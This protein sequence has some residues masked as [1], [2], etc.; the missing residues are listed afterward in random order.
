MLSIVHP[1]DRKTVAEAFLR[2]RS[3]P[4]V[5]PASVY[6]VRTASGEWR[7]IEVVATNCLDDPAVAG[8]VI[9]ARDVTE[10]TN[11][12][13]VL[14]TLSEANRVLVSVPDEAS[15]L[16][17]VCRT[18]VDVGNYRLAWVGYSVHD[19]ERTVRPVGC[20]GQSGY[21]D[22]IA[23]SWR[24]DERG[25]GPVGAA[26]RT[27]SVQVVEDTC[28]A[29]EFAPWRAAAAEYGFRSCCA[30]PLKVNDEVIGALVIYAAEPAA[31]GPPEVALLKE[32]ADDLSYGVGRHR[33]AAS[34]QVSEERFRTLAAAA[35]IGIL[36]VSPMAGVNY[37]NPRVAEIITGREIG[38]LTGRGWLDALHPDD[39]PGLLAL[40]DGAGP[41]RAQVATKFRVKR[42]S[43]EVRHV[44]LLAAPRGRDVN[45]GYV[46]TVEDI[47]EE[48]QAQEALAHQA[49][50]DTLTGLPNRALFLDRLGQELARR[51]RDG[52]K[53]AVLFFDLDRFKVV[54]DSLGHQT[55][56]AVLKE[57]GDRFMR[58]VRAG[59]TAARFSGD[60]FVFIIREVHGVQDAF[61]AARRL[62]AV[63]EPPV[64]CGDHEITVT[65]SVGIAIPSAGADALTVLRDADAA[66]HQAKEEG[67]NRCALFD[68]ALHS[69]SVTRLAI[70]GELRQ[71]LARHELE[72]HY[73]PV[74]EPASGRPVGAEALVRWRHPA[75]GLVAPLDF[76]PVAEDSGLIKP[77]GRWVFEQAMGQLARWDAEDNG[78]RLEVLAVN[79][80]ARQ[81]DDP[82]T[83]DMVSH[84]LKLYGISPG[85]ACVEVTESAVMVDSVPTRHSL[86]A[87]KDLGLR[88]AID[89]FGT[90]YSSLAYLHTLPVT[91][92]KVDRSFVERLGGADDSTPVV[93]AVVEMGHAMGLGVVAEGVSSAH[94][95]ELVAHLGCDAAQGF[96]WA[97]AMPAEEFAAW[98]RKSQVLSSAAR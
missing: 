80:S 58:N 33:D 71:A 15:L 73:Q 10:R 60:M 2:D 1:D 81:L 54:N 74:V 3:M 34:L 14:R 62:Q 39:A 24:D 16:A 51:R 83:P 66:V 26:I 50:Y 64:R 97:R 65:G 57:L 63:L 84:A 72:L 6:R 40:F 69:R 5:H 29:E 20:A 78:P 67:H 41:E 9:N 38:E 42:P 52:P 79:L 91:T 21:V 22:G 96:Y 8:I 36:E 53:I 25:R 82:E 75:R 13:R 94:L 7:S 76:I 61:A 47:T 19:D 93:R 85:R 89:D 11:L 43:G 90:G 59:E 12:T 37:A 18:M 56:D 44:R 68:E 49:F 55:G 27:R 30:L 32:L 46:V 28:S 23:V 92:V 95:R 35:P 45:C 98:W 88:V 48:V 86:Q 70:E 77:V 87:F 31:F 4:G 17:N